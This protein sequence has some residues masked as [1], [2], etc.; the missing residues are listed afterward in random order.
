[1]A[2]LSPEKAFERLKSKTTKAMSDYFPLEG[3]KQ[4]LRAKRFWV[5]DKRHIDD[6]RSQ[7]EAKE[8]GRSWTVPIKA[9]L[10]LVDNASGKVIDTK[11]VTMAQLPKITRRYSYIVNGNEWQVNNQF[12]LK[13]GVYTRIKDNGQ[14]EGQWNLEKGL[15][16]KMNFD[17]K[18]RK[19]TMKYGGANVPLYPILKTLGMDDDTI[20]RRW[21][22]EILSANRTVGGHEAAIKQLYKTMTGEKAEN[23]VDAEKKILET[24]AA[25]S[26]R[27]DSTAMTLGKEFGTVDGASLLAGSNKILRVSRGKDEPDDRDSLVF[28]DFLSAEDLVAE[29]IEKDAR[30]EINRKLGSKLD[31]RDK[32]RDIVNPDIF[33]RPM[34]TFFTNSAIS[35]QPTQMNPMNF[36]GGARRTTIGGQHGITDEH[37]ITLGAQSINKSHIGFLDPIQTPE[38]SR[39]GTILQMALGTRKVGKEIRMNAYNVKTGKTELIPVDKA[40]KANVAFPDQYKWVDGKP[41]PIGKDVKISDSRG[42]MT[43]TNPG[44]VDYIIKSSKQMFDVAANTIPFLQNNQGNRTMVAAKQLEQGVSLVQREAPLVQTQGEGGGTFEDALGKFNSHASPVNGEVVSVR[45]DA[46]TV[47]DGEGKKH[48]V[49]IYDDFPLNDS[50]SVLNSESRVKKGDKVKRGQTIADSNF[51]RDGTLALGTNL[52]VAYMPYQGYNFED[53]IVISES[54]AKKLT[55][56]HMLRNTIRAEKGII[57][58]KKQFLAETAGQISGEQAEKLDDHGVIQVGQIVQPGDVLIGALKEAKISP[59]QQQLALFSKKA[60]KPVRVNSQ[61][62]DKEYE[63]VVSKVIRHGKDT[64]VYVKAKTAAQ[65]GDKMVGRH[66][67]K[68]IITRILPDHEMPATGEGEHMQVLLNPTGIPTRINLGQV[69]ETSASKIARKTGR[70]YVVNNFDPN[71]PDYTRSLIKEMKKHGVSDTETLFDPQTGKK[72]GEVLTGEQYILKLHHTAEKGITARGRG[73][74]DAN[75]QPKKGGETSAQSMDAAG[76]YSLLAHGAKENIR[77]MQ[78]V[79][80]DMNDDYWTALQ[81]GEAPPPPRVP[82]AYTKF[83]GYLK[84]MGVNVNKDGNKISLSPLTDKQTL[85]MSNGEIR[86][87]KAIIRSKDLKPEPG[88]LYDPVIT[89]TTWVGGVGSFGDKWAHFE[90]AQRMPN[91]IFEKPVRSLLGLGQKDFDAIMS[92]DKDHEGKTGPW[93]I[94]SALK[95]VDVPK[96]MAEL[97]SKLPK[98]KSAKLN[99]AT[100]EMRYLRALDKL[101]MSPKEAYTVK[102]LPVLP[103]NMRPISVL[104]NGDLNNDDLTDHYKN[105]G[106]V[107]DK[108]KSR[109]HGGVFPEEEYKDLQIALYD[110]LKS[111][112]MTGMQ[113]HGRHRKGVTQLIG[114]GGGGGS[115]KMGFFQR[116]LIGKRQDLSMRGVIVPEPTLGLDEV[117]IPEKAAREIY[118]PFVVRRLTRMGKTPGGAIREVRSN[119]PLARAALEAEIGE[120]PLMLKR[121]P[122]LHKYGVQ[123]FKPT[124]TDGKAIKIHPLATSGYN[125]D[126]DGDKMS[127]FVPI[128]N[129]AV[130]EAY[131]MMPSRNL[132]SP[133]DGK[134]MYAPN[135]ESQLGLYNLSKRGKKT[136]YRFKTSADAAKAVKDG[137]IGITDVVTID[138]ISGTIPKNVDPTH[139]G[140]ID[141]LA[142]AAPVETTVGRLLLHQ[143]LPDKIR[144]KKMLTD[145]NF[146]LTK[147]ELKRL[148]TEVGQKETKEFGR[149]A[150]RLKDLGNSSSTGFSFG[151]KDLVSDSEFRDKAMSKARVQEKKIRVAEKNTNKRDEQLVRLYQGVDKKVQQHTKARAEKSKN[152]MYDWVRSGARGSWDQ[153]RQMTVAP[154]LVEDALGKVVPVP[155]DKSYSEG[156]DTGSYWA[157]MYGARMGT[158]GRVKGTSKPGAATKEMMQTSMSMVIS[159][160]DCGTD[161]G[162]N[163]SATDKMALDRY[164]AKG[165][166]L[167]VKGKKDKGSIPKGTLITPAVLT[168]LRNNKVKDVTVRSPLKCKA[169]E[170]MCAHCFGLSENG[171][172]LER[173]A[174]IGV[175]AAQALGEPLTQMAMNAFHTGGVQTERGSS[176]DKF[177]RAQQLV[178]FPEVLP[179]S[180]TL[181]TMAGKVE[182]VTIDRATGGHNVHVEGVG[183]YVPPSKGKP[184]VRKGM[185]LKRG[186]ALTDGPKNPRELL[187]LT[188]KAT[189][190][191]YLTDELQS[192]YGGSNLHRRN[193][194]V[195]VRSLTNLAEVTDPS[196]NSGFLPGDKMAASQIEA[197]NADLP[198][199]FKPVKYKPLL[200]GTNVLP[201]E[202]QTDWM[203]RLQFRDLKRTIIQGAAEGWSSDV[204]GIHP[205]PG[206]ATASEFGKGTPKDPWRF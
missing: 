4:T 178:R 92:R 116:R 170:G 120:R 184:L 3:K 18:S 101:K 104:D 20:E 95:Q 190:Q 145:P 43:I 82:F 148:L 198:K 60:L 48:T 125:A 74:Y 6:I 102:Q 78:T 149:T 140:T 153:Y 36:I 185:M 86:D 111:M 99:A 38:S 156:L 51:T 123:A 179:G 1:M 152:R 103:A 110:G 97:E 113:Y 80:A 33:G 93:A 127:A 131:N 195:F 12:R 32:I 65:I 100:K 8:A 162:L 139:I 71:N 147:Q 75:M 41:V 204:H 175:I 77:E 199:G 96:R 55:S 182:K 191:R 164:T 58:N 138:S 54:A 176:A 24:F 28:K 44:E 121:D 9:E 143:A 17:P 205:I 56:E 177:T 27:K 15:G 188:N 84:A 62:W 163:L 142:A 2:E 52:R 155:I 45:K 70:P 201:N 40:M 129:R 172:R 133:S 193:T 128:S 66:G 151:L 157:S 203:A 88:G 122:V 26:L 202:V 34:Q 117:A 16:F 169:H 14:L 189:V 49:Q 7:K 200:R 105:I 106:A 25:T 154:M 13:S 119:T 196:G 167:G 186:D 192:L 10:E 50:K 37:K 107:N 194:E 161:R 76:L 68:G 59:E 160:D 67:N 90:L 83:E 39:I 165:I 124:L 98:L 181:S 19:M 206:M 187:P 30:R 130:T 46:I 114:G 159:M 22:K 134:L 73:A 115:P 174:N 112:T 69:L 81:A 89:G 94:S 5:D 136:R 11:K 126:F 72:F 42:D 135:Q 109:L 168:R 47:K 132:F 21:G 141:K 53:G 29:R 150:D 183:H 91:P 79:K 63:G 57:L 23:L 180:A 85:A 171:K 108:L 197:H 118:K 144:N 64:T 158:I 166:S 173:G 35:E 87:P 146:A 31:K 137:K 61:T